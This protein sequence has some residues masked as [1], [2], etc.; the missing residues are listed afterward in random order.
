MANEFPVKKML[1]CGVDIS[2]YRIV[3][4]REAAQ[5]VKDA[6]DTLA[7]M[8]QKAVGCGLQVI[9]E[10]ETA[11]HEIV[12]G[13]TNRNTEAV[14][15]AKASV[16]NDGY[17]ILAEGS[18]LFITGNLDRGV[19]Y[20]VYSL[21]E[22]YVGVCFFASDCTVIREAETVEVPRDIR[23]VY[24]PRFEYRDIGW[25][26]RMEDLSLA[27]RNKLNSVCGRRTDKP[28]ANVYA[29]RFVHTLSIL[30][31]GGHEIDSQP[32]LTDETVYQT[33]LCNVKK[34]LSENPDASVISVSQNDS[35][36]EGLGCQCEKCRAIDEAEGGTPMG[37]LLAFVNRIAGDIREEYPDVVV[38]TLSYR[39]TRKPPRK[40]VPAEN[41]AIRLCSIEYCFAHPL[42]GTDCE[43]NVDFKN[44][45][46]TW[47]RLCKRMYIWDY[48]T[49]F[50]HYLAPFPNLAIL[51]DNIQFF[52]NNGVAGIYEQG[53]YQSL[54]GEF[55][56]L[57]GYLLSN[58]LWNPDMTK[59]EYFAMMDEFL[60]A[61][62]GAG[63]RHI[64]RYIDKTSAKAAETHLHIYDKP[65]EYR[66]ADDVDS[67][68][69]MRFADLMTELWEKALEEA[70]TEEHRKHVKKSRIQNE[71][72]NL[73]TDFNQQIERNR[74]FYEN[75][76]EAGITWFCEPWELPELEDF[77][78]E[79]KMWPKYCRE[80]SRKNK[81]E[82]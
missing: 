59:T 70:R 62:Y 65:D 80:L 24:S 60:E 19:S 55:G 49:D 34:W 69:G 57:R 40:M 16:K 29:E 54:S 35:H 47:S 45:L 76:K 67:E 33:V 73:Y 5:C 79:P 7:E 18:R 22:D 13:D 26:D 3:C 61:Y 66:P 28:E 64:R 75:L 30:N 41:V 23:V 12:I 42:D 11:A 81:A 8:V 15:Q 9:G 78:L 25:Y 68:T 74:A 43:E 31:G 63:W 77:S 50:A 46:Q 6:V 32:C 52:K 20:G 2:E 82:E 37:S 53:N 21:L 1:I 39:Y 4:A 56:E 72:Y 58:L 14:L 17:V 44:L 71:Y 38:D 10:N 27:C 36:A 51:W 48:T